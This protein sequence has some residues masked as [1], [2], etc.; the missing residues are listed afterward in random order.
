MS[1]KFML[2]SFDALAKNVTLESSLDIFLLL[3]L[4][5]AEMIKTFP[6]RS[7][8]LLDT[9]YGF[10]HQKQNKSRFRNV[11]FDKI[12]LANLNLL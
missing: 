10:L 9:L 4:D 1:S 6:L 2:L 11:K 12:K 5:S 7:F 8:T 3:E